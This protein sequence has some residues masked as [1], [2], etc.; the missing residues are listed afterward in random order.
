MNEQE[1]LMCGCIIGTEDD[2]FI[3]IPCSPDCK[4]LRFYI[5]E[6]EAKMPGIL[7]GMQMLEIV[8]AER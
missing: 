3:I 1:V 2:Q 6:I 7:E 8:E 5:E 4:L